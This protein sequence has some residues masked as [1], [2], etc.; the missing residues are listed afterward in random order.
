[1]VWSEWARKVRSVECKKQIFG[2]NKKG[3]ILA[4]FRVMESI[5]LLFLCF[6]KICIKI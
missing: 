4:N 3:K 2:K 5:N 1:M 6:M